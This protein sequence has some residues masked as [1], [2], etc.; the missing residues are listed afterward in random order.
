MDISKFRVRHLTKKFK[1]NLM[2][3]YRENQTANIKNSS[4]LELIATTKSNIKFELCLY[5]QNKE[6]IALTAYNFPIESGKKQQIP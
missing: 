2:E 6:R 3:K 5:I 4:K 1:L